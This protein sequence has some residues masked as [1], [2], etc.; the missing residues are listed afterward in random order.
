MTPPKVPFTKVCT[1]CK[2]S[3]QTFS[4]RLKICQDCKDKTHTVACAHCKKD[5]IRND[6]SR[7]CKSCKDIKV[8]C[9]CG[10]GLILPAYDAH[11]AQVFTIRYKRGH[12]R[13]NKH[14]TESHNL[15]ISEANKGQHTGT[16]WNKGK[17]G[18]YKVSEETKQLMRNIAKL[19][20]F[21]KW[22]LGRKLPQCVRDLISKTNTGR[23]VSESTKTKISAKNAGEGNGM[24][25][26]GLSRLP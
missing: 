5:Y 4:N 17:T 23:I 3:V 10:C 21:G 15:A 9:S 20:G 13:R 16:P 6:N 2:K 7:I 18:L 14:N 1:V 19:K 24:W 26:G 12:A 22:M 8:S 25:C 11:S